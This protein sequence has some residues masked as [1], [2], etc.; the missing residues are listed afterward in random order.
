MHGTI[1]SSTE[2]C[3]DLVRA[4]AAG[5]FAMLLQYLNKLLSVTLAGACIFAEADE[6]FDSFYTCCCQCCCR[7]PSLLPP[8]QCSCCCRRWGCLLPGSL[9]K[10]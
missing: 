10:R 3:I 4:A 2:S 7:T 5:L 8:H 9:M 1:R 6:P